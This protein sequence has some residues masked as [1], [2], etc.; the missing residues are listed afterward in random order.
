MSIIRQGLLSLNWKSVGIDQVEVVENGFDAQKVLEIQG[1]DLLISDIRMPGM[2]GLELAEYIKKYSIDTAVIILTGYTDFEYA[3]NAIK[4]DVY[5]FMLKP[6]RPKDILATVANVLQ[7]LEQKR[8][9]DQIVR[10][11]E[12][13]EP[14]YD[15]KSQLLNC[16][17][18]MNPKMVDIII[19]MA[20]HYSEDISL[21]ELADLYYY[22]VP[23]L[24]KFIKQET[25]YHYKD[26]MTGIRLM[27]GAQ[28]LL[29][30]RKDN[31]NI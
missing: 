30:K 4:N 18:D 31:H 2:T 6:I 3:R 25:G 29:E 7:K 15:T 23:Y 21:S 19:Y 12:K 28:L 10:D 22:S 1:I 17:G 8:Y 20:E 9:Q 16:F 13:T 11:Y 24:S 26:I 14:Q 27:N 5:D